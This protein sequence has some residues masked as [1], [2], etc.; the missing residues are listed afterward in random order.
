VLPIGKTFTYEVDRSGKVRSIRGLDELMN[1][2][3][4]ATV[5]ES[6]DNSFVNVMSDDDVVAGETADWNSRIG[7]LV[8]RKFNT[9][10]VWTTTDRLDLPYGRKLTYYTT[11]RVVGREKR[12]GHDCVRIRFVSSSNPRAAAGKATKAGARGSRRRPAPTGGA[13]AAGVSISESGER[14]VDPVTMLVYAE[15]STRT[16]KLKID[17]LGEENVP[18]TVIEKREY[19]YRYE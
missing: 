6:T 19:R 17:A 3:S 12:N 13:P 18:T 15:S 4:A 7:S 5:A 11:T 10:A 14:V 16:V 8:G 1:E 2:L 9:G